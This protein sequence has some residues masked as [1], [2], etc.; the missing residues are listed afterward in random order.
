MSPPHGTD[1]K[2]EF[3]RRMSATPGIT[4]HVAAFF[5]LSVTARRGTYSGEK[6]EGASRKRE[7]FSTA[8]GRLQASGVLRPEY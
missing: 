6:R 7:R 1:E 8:C 3:W 5:L 2:T 4:W